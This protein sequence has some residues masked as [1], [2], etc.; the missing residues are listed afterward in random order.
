ML[1]LSGISKFFFFNLTSIGG[2]SDNNFS[3]EQVLKE[4]SKYWEDAKW[5]LEDKEL[6]EK[7]GQRRFSGILVN[8]ARKKSILA[9]NQVTG[10]TRSALSRCA[11]S[12]SSQRKRASRTKDHGS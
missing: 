11:A 12:G 2:S 6:I 8:S 7:R 9:Q 4:I 3:V 5:V 1:P 10:C